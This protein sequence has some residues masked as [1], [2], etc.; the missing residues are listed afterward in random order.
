MNHPFEQSLIGLLGGLLLL[1]VFAML[2]I[3]RIFSMIRI[4]VLQGIIL[5][6]STLTVGLVSGERHLLF[7]SLLTF[8]LKVVLL[9]VLL[10]RLIRRLRLRGD[11]EVVLNVP[12]TMVA[13][14][15]LVIFSFSVA[16]PLA[17]MAMTVSRGLIGVGLATVLLSFL[18]V[19]T[20]RKAVT[21]VLGLLSLENG[22]LFSATNA[23][24]GMPM[25]VELGV[26]L[27][28]LVG[29]LLF[30]VFFFQIRD[31]FEKLDLDRLERT[32]ED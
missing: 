32:W 29:T 25:V 10:F 21:Q 26:A 5:S 2:S 9:P 12:V 11:V 14:I 15:L 16:S 1:T 23:T 19:L 4:F 20:R 22:L 18:V 17:R 6:A 3:R 31:N 24:Y 28:V 13:G 27:D 8:L 7:Q 30:G